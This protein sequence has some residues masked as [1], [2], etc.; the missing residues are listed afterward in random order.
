MSVPGD[1]LG[2][3]TKKSVTINDNVITTVENGETFASVMV[4]PTEGES[5][6]KRRHRPTKIPKTNER[7]LMIGRTQPQG[8]SVQCISSNADVKQV[9]EGDQKPEALGIKSSN[10]ALVDVAENTDRTCRLETYGGGESW[11]QNQQM[12][13]EW[14]LRHFPKGTDK[15]WDKIA[16]Q[17]PGKSKVSV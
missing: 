11:T 4:L 10:G 7:T 3:K 9:S 2:K 1:I 8:D 16:D 14:A 13:F 5:T 17:I 12:I 6:S 15:R